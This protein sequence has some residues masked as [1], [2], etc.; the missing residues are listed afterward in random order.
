M[1]AS[2]IEHHDHQHFRWQTPTV[3]LQ[4]EGHDRRVDSGQQQP[5]HRTRAGFDTGIQV[6]PDVLGA[7]GCQRTLSTFSPPPTI[8]GFETKTC[9]VL[10]TQQNLFVGVVEAKPGG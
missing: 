3:V 4:I 9:F 5:E 10:K 6:G 8:A 2:P 1:P 7:T